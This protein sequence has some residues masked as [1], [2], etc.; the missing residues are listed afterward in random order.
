[1][2]D[3]RHLWRGIHDP[4]T[5]RAGLRIETS[6]PALA[7]GQIA[8]TVEI[9]NHGVGHAFPTYVTPRVVVEIGQESTAGKLIADTVDRHLIARDV[10][11]D[12]ST[13]L[14]DTR[15]M[16]DEV[17]RY[18]YQHPRH[19][20]ARRLVARITVEPDA[21]YTEFYRATLR[22]SSQVKGRASIREALRRTEAS[23]YLLYQAQFDLA[24]KS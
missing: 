18:T 17:R 16:P 2:P 7:G 1:M 19:P 3:R 11:L 21:F 9:T 14:D 10:S 13:E 6:P 22:D 24:F 8:S 23:P 20:Q 15:I 12:L 4:E 5:V